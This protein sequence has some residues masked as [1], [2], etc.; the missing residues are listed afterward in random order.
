MK[1]EYQR[2]AI[3][4]LDAARV[5]LD[6]GIHEIAAFNCYHAY[7]STAS[8]LALSLHSPHGGGVHHKD[9]LNIF[10]QYVEQIGN[11][12][13]LHQ[14]RRLNGRLESL[15]NKLLYPTQARYSQTIVIPENVITAQQ[16]EGLIQ[17]VQEIVNWVGQ[18]I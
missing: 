18:Q 16:V 9:K 11:D 10:L 2:I 15:R 14:V 7:E 8:A 3:R 13:I 6:A 17:N 5:T 4:T 12:R 1:Q